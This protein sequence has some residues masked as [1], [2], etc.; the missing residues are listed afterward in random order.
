M[1]GDRRDPEQRTGPLQDMGLPERE[2]MSDTPLNDAR[3]LA[4]F[5]GQWQVTRQITP[6]TGP[7]ARFSGA[8][9]W[10]KAQ[11]GMNY[12]E[13]GVMTLE[14]HP[15]MQAERRYF[16]AEDLSVFFEDGRF[17]HRVPH[18]GGTA[19]HWCDP[20]HYEVAY[21]FSLW[22]RFHVV[23]QVSGPRKSYR[24]ETEYRRA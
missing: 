1:T 23:W 21:D 9:G 22:P 7:P 20:D 18:T 3:C 19:A 16:W 15:P 24:S 4:D 6:E 13:R 10:T 8:A 11:G 14:G 5:A 12:A 2:R 17:F